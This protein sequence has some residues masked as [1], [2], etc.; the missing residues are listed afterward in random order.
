M[1][2]GNVMF[3]IAEAVYYCEK[4]NYHLCI[5]KVYEKFFNHILLNDKNDGISIENDY[6]FNRII[7]NGDNLK[8]TGFS[9]VHLA[10]KC[11]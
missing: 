9:S 1:G 7:P 5:N 3:Q 4:Y 8:I 10:L 11:S 2:N 6:K